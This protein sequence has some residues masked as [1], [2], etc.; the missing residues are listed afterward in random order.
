MSTE[1]ARERAEKTPKALERRQARRRAPRRRVTNALCEIPETGQRS[2]QEH[3]IITNDDAADVRMLSAKVAST[4]AAL[5]AYFQHYGSTKE[6]AQAAALDSSKYSAEQARVCPPQE[7]TWDRIGHLADIDLGEATLAWLKVQ[8]YAYDELE[9][10]VRSAEA[11][12]N[13]SPLERARFLALRDKFIDQWQPAGGIDAAMIDMLA[14]AYSLQLHW[15]EIAFTRSTQFAD[16]MREELKRYESN[17]WKP[18]YQSAAD[19]I[20]QANRLADSYNRQFLRVL[21]QMRD[22]RRYAPPVIVNN[23]GQVN[24]A[25]Q[26]VNVSRK[27]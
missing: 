22:L 3:V 6:E 12:G 11:A 27:E 15:T 10:G 5:V 2:E 8:D 1:R 7:Q 21:R 25:N 16:S 17:G 13:T 9:S 20:D 18:P 19:A 26:Q 24:V 23:G 4:H 14:Q